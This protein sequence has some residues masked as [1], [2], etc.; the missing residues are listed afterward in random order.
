MF[1]FFGKSL[2]GTVA[3]RVW[4]PFTA[5]DPEALAPLAFQNGKEL[6]LEPLKKGA[7]LP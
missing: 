1:R 3:L 2:S 7:R 6:G 4:K 5:L